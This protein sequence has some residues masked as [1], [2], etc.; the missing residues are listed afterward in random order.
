ME[1]VGESDGTVAHSSENEA[2]ETRRV[3]RG[4]EGKRLEEE[5]EGKHVR[6]GAA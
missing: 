5:R 4:K 6:D 1:G 3:G 2:R